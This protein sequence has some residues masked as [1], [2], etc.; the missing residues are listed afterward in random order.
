MIAVAQ[1]KPAERRDGR[2][3]P[4]IL[5]RDDAPSTLGGRALVAFRGKGAPS[6]AR[7]W[8]TASEVARWIGYATV[9]G[10]T[11][12]ADRHEAELGADQSLSTVET[13]LGSREVRVFT[14]VG[15]IKLA[16]L[17]ELGAGRELRDRLAHE[18]AERV[19]KVERCP[20]DGSR[21]SRAQGVLAD[22]A[23][24]IEALRDEVSGSKDETLALTDVLGSV[25]EQAELLEV[26]RTKRIPRAAGAVPVSAQLA[27]LLN[28][29][30]P[31]SRARGTA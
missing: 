16:L 10:L 7:A 6:T 17:S 29:T 28:T 13:D 30:E 22:A 9:A 26:L 11:K 27:R 14:R 24:K 8:I 5:E 19:A 3:A 15:A 21:A 2:T 4:A 23:G 12:L 25:D 1:K 20:K 18:L 31:R